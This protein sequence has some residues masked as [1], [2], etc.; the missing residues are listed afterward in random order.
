MTGDGKSVRKNINTNHWRLRPH[1]SLVRDEEQNEN[2]KSPQFRTSRL[3]TPNNL[4]QN[5]D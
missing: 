2:P 5:M 1:T 4:E 3:L